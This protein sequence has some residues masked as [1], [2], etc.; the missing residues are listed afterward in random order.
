MKKRKVVNYALC[1]GLAVTMAV[2]QPAAVLASTE[3]AAETETQGNNEITEEEALDLINA[4]EKTNTETEEN[5]E[6]SGV[7]ETTEPSIEET[8]GTAETTEAEETVTEE[9]TDDGIELFSVEAGDDI[10][11]KNDQAF[12][13][14]PTV[15]MPTNL[16]DGTYEL[17]FRL[18]AFPA[19]SSTFENKNETVEPYG[20]YKYAQTSMGNVTFSTVDDNLLNYAT[21]TVK[22]GVA[23]VTLYWRPDIG[24]YQFNW[25]E[26]AEGL[27]NKDKKGGYPG[28]EADDTHYEYEAD[29]P[30][31]NR[32]VDAITSM[33]FTPPS[34]NPVVYIS[35]KA[36]G[37]MDSE[38]DAF[39][40][41]YWDYLTP[42]DVPEPEVDTE[43]PTA[44]SNVEA[45]HITAITATVSWEASTDNV[46]VEKYEIYNG[47]TLL[48]STTEET[49]AELKNLTADTVYK[50]SVYAYDEAGNKS[51]AGTVEFNTE[52][53][54][55]DQ[56][57]EPEIQDELVQSFQELKAYVEALDPNE[58][59]LVENVWTMASQDPNYNLVYEELR[60][61][62]LAKEKYI[63][64]NGNIIPEADREAFEAELLTWDAKL[65]SPQYFG[66]IYPM[67]SSDAS[68]LYD[69]T[70]EI[71]VTFYDA[72]TE[73]VT[74]PLGNT[75][76]VFTRGAENTLLNDASTGIAKVK[77]SIDSSTLAQRVAVTLSLPKT[78]GDY[79]ISLSKNS[80]VANVNAFSNSSVNFNATY[81][82]MYGTL[83]V[84]PTEG[85]ASQS[86]VI[87]A[88]DWTSATDATGTEITANKTTLQSY[89]SSINQMAKGNITNSYPAAWPQAVSVEIKESG[90]IDEAQAVLDN[91]NATQAE[92]NDM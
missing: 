63:A 58:Y 57:E 32:I 15:T 39:L 68:I 8:T 59:F 71:P 6:G 19:P 77:I 31:E 69:R 48:A 61:W 28:D 2:G 60:E 17:P 10:N 44:P 43:A 92:I 20:N 87:V 83:T 56:E 18:F 79:T 5:T 25:Y 53:D 90:L 49:T 26:N 78:S 81:W 70:Y 4:Y 41:F 67:N 72:A 40:A 12:Y 85:E 14:V 23:R 13:T 35:V 1:T 7:T 46:G 66:K 38:Q 51:E 24:C 80:D 34:E 21:V 27:K 50:L 42:V 54:T 75:A 3:T 45:S 52:A 37:M 22:D 65:V 88:L 91:D 16:A 30:Y 89:V 33:T 36:A 64:V 76:E 74:T 47:T 82:D 84:T 62:L 9:E 29:Y 55:G 86:T 73:T 11:Q